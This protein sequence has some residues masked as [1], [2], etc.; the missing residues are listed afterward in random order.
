M[1]RY[2]IELICIAS[3]TVRAIRTAARIEFGQNGTDDW[4]AR[5]RKTLDRAEEITL[6]RHPGLNHERHA[7]EVADGLHDKPGQRATATKKTAARG[8]RKSG[9]DSDPNLSLL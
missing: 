2:H 8:K 7:Q 5:C 9:A 3:T 1:S 6:A 4:R